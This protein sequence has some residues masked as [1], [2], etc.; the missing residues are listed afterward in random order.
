M[1]YDAKAERLHLAR[2]EHDELLA[3][4]PELL[5]TLFG[6]QN[7]RWSIGSVSFIVPQ[8]VADDVLLALLAAP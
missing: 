8:G 4:N 1:N 5:R 3:A 7:T 6:Y 2:A